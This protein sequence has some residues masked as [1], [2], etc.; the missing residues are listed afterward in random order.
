MHYVIA[1]DVNCPI[2]ASSQ[3][4]FDHALCALRPHRDNYN[5]ATNLFLDAEGLFKCVPIRLVD[6]K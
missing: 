6:F 3:S 4:V 5:F 1:D 2:R